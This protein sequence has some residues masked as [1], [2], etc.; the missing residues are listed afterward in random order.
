MF[1]W[2]KKLFG[3]KSYDSSKGR[4]YH[5]SLPYKLSASNVMYA[6][7]ML[8]WKGVWNNVP[9]D[10]QLKLEHASSKWRSV[11]VTKADLDRLDNKTWKIIADKLNL[12][13]SD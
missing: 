1:N 3:R 7:R 6:I 8:K 4:T 13:W 11:K 10:L 2:L 9:E 5:F 12:K